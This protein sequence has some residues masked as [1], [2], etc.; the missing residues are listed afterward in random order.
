MKELEQE[1]KTF[2]VNMICDCEQGFLI[3]TGKFKPGLAKGTVQFM[4]KCSK[5]GKVVEL[6]TKYPM[7]QY[8]PIKKD[9]D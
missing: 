2:L 8:E 1:V 5:C 7:T 4:H 3:C 9:A 6:K